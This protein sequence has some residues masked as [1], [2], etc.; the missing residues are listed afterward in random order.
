[1][2]LYSDTDDFR[3]TLDKIGPIGEEIEE[4]HSTQPFLD[5]VEENLPKANDGD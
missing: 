3:Y 5:I 2:I 4:N 1:M